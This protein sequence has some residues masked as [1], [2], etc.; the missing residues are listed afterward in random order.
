MK[1]FLD[2]YDTVIFDLDG[3]LTGENNYWNCA[4]LTV[5]EFLKGEKG[6][7]EDIGTVRREVFCGDELISILKGKGVNSNWDLGYVT[8]LISIIEDTEDFSKVTEYAR[9]LGD[10]IL[11]EYERL[12]ELAKDKLQCD[13]E[14]TRRNGKLWCDMH[15][16]FQEWFL[17][18]KL[19][20]E[21]YGIAAKH[22]QRPGM[23]YSEMPI[24]PLEASQDLLKE[25]SRTKRLCTGTGRPSDEML[26]P[27]KK[28]GVAKYFAADGLCNFDHVA[29]AEKSFNLNLTKPHPYSFLKAL[30]GTGY[31]DSK[32]INGDYDKSRIKRTLVVG[33]AGADILAA[34][35][36]GADF[37]AVLT[38]ING[39]AA[40]SFFEDLKAEYILNSV[41]DM[42]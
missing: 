13:I 21:R 38:G 17:G 18:G 37:C 39:K 40:R 2:K 8:Y 15:S 9:G 1:S 26:V 5:W 20:S 23:V 31:D 14:Y 41:I 28:W 36:M 12:A 33:D 35:A 34:R 19:F 24:V 32:I 42:V 16:S 3:V 10:N 11:D 29:N 7:P 25:L 6:I 30:Y 27:L 4:A 22:P